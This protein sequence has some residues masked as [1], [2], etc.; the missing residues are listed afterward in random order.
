MLV[1]VFSKG[2]TGKDATA[3]FRQGASLQPEHDPLDQNPPL[4]A[5][6]IR[7]GTPA[8][9]TRGMGVAEMA[10]HRRVYRPG[11]GLA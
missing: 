8:L 11:S 1:D 2:L 6:G 4:K 3:A 9:T 10:G 7:I 5:S